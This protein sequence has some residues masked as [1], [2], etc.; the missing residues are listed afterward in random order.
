MRRRRAEAHV[1]AGF[2][3]RPDRVRVL[4]RH[5]GYPHP[6]VRDAAVLL[7]A[8]AG[9]DPRDATSLDEPVP[10]Y[11]A[12]LENGV[13]GLQVGVVAEAFG[14]GVEPGVSDSVRASVDRLQ[15]SARP[16]GEATL[17]HA[18]YRCRP[19]T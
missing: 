16:V 18:E 8:I 11:L 5:R 1:R 19:T 3:V 10:D 17:P 13:K 7:G 12:G 4:A 6:D 9:K 2:P 15:G 14:E